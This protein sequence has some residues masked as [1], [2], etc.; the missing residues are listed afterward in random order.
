MNIIVFFR[1]KEQS[2]AIASATKNKIDQLNRKVI[3]LNTL[4]LNV[5]FINLD[6]KNYMKELNREDFKADCIYLWEDEDIIKDYIEVNNPEAKLI[7]YKIYILRN[8]H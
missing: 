6:K 4:S 5:E 3:D 8:I 7:T 1:S 2:N